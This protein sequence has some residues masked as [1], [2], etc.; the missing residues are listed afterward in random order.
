MRL[1]HVFKECEFVNLNGFPYNLSKI[2]DSNELE[3]PQ[4]TP[5]NHLARVS[6]LP[7]SFT[8]LLPPS[9]LHL[10]LLLS[11]SGK[12]HLTICT[13]LGS[14]DVDEMRLR[15]N[16]FRAIY[17]ADSFPLALRSHSNDADTHSN[18][19]PSPD[20]K[21]AIQACNIPD[22]W[23]PHVIISQSSLQN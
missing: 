21:S 3:T 15:Y 14:D 7:S 4:T 13:H 19:Y 17:R 5:G 11:L 9:A 2:Q 10:A 12:M 16:R 18:W 22:S 23:W 8:I 6:E 1:W 20:R